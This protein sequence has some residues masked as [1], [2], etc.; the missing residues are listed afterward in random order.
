MSD[1]TQPRSGNVTAAASDVTI[2]AQVQAAQEIIKAQKK[3]AIP[4]INLTEDNSEL[5]LKNQVIHY[6]SLL[7]WAT[8]RQDNRKQRQ[9]LTVD[10]K[11]IVLA[12]D[13]SGSGFLA[14]GKVESVG[15]SARTEAKKEKAKKGFQC[16]IC[17]ESFVS[18][19]NLIQH[20]RANHKSEKKFLQ[21]EICSFSAFHKSH[22]QEHVRYVHEK[23]RPFKCDLCHFSSVRKATLEKHVTAV[24]SE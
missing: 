2:E 11:K 10:K 17:D 16:S 1:V 3:R 21:C 13:K 23:A 19:R 12:E 22:L 7:M 14:T 5:I 20:F 9:R 8:L 4:V 24:H 15:I 18:K 6:P